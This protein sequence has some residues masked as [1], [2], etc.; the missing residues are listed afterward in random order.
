MNILLLGSGGREHALAWKI[1]Q[2]HHCS[3]LFIAP[4]NAGTLLHGTNLPF[5]VNDF[6]GAFTKTG[7]G[8]PQRYEREYRELLQRTQTT[9]PGARLVIGEPYALKGV[10]PRIDAWYPEFV[11]YP[12]VARKIADEFNAIFIPYQRIY[13][14]AGADAPAKYYS[15]DGMHPSLGGIELMSKAWLDS[16]GI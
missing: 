1:S 12:A 3:K 13:D 7:H 15:K 4:G 8:D 6:D 5:G 10:A 11:E 16:T 2:S 14:E 9:L